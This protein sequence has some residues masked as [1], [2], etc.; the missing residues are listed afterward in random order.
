MSNDIIE[1]VNC[2]TT[3]FEQINQIRI[4][5]FGSAVSNHNPNDIDILI[6]YKDVTHPQKIREI[7]ENFS[8]QF[9]HLLFLT[10]EEENETNFIA[11]QKCVSVH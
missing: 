4:Y 1:I 9:I 5:A 3:K 10:S 8:Y 7:L 11:A 2:I 6:I